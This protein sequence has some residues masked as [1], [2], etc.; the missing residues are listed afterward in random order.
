MKGLVTDLENS[1]SQ[2][3]SDSV[4]QK[5]AVS[6][7]VLSKAVIDRAT[8]LRAISDLEIQADPRRAREWEGGL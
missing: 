2:C 7:K 8:L 1:V 5:G 6:I 3:V 4:R